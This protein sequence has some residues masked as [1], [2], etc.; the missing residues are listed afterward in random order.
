VKAQA[1][2]VRADLILKQLAKRH[3]GGNNPDVFLTEVKNGESYVAT[4]RMLKVDAMAIR[5]SW[6]HPCVIAY[7]VKVDRGDFLRDTKWPRYLDLCN[8]L[9]FACPTG[10]ISPDELMPGVGLLYYSPEKDSLRTQRKA[11]FRQVDIPLDMLWYII[12][13][14]VNSDSKHPFFSSEREYLEEW[15]RDKNDRKELGGSVSGKLFYRMIDQKNK[16]S[17]LER[18]IERLESRD[19]T[20][21]EQLDQLRQLATKAGASQYQA[22]HY[23]AG[24]IEKAMKVSVSK[25]MA[26]LVDSLE[27]NASK[28]KSMVGVTS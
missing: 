13:Y 23:P 9:S 14:R 26:N 15:V 2:K 11:A 10:L 1:Q 5:K 25:E 4:G 8:E 22:T 20:D 16:I 17:E 6:A 12:M 24:F 28:L 19:E 7:E 18:Q 27:Q 21:R 3:S